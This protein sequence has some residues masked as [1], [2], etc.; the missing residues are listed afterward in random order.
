MDTSDNTQVDFYLLADSSERGIWQFCCRLT[1][2]AWKLGNRIHI[3]TI[4]ED[5][6][7]RLDDMLWTYSDESFLPHAIHDEEKET[8]VIQ[9]PITLGHTHNASTCDL[10]INLAVT[11]PHEVRRYPR[12]AEILNEDENIKQYG[13]ERYS[14]YRQDG[15]KVQHHQ[16]GS[17]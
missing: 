9:S 10:L 14:Q 12:I 11:A 16:I 4:D 2:K 6:T 5:E 8:D 3:R 15:C 7:R 13:R 17:R 1:E